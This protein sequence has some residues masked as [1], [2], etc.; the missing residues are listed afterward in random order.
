MWRF[1]LVTFG[2]LG[3]AF[4]ELSGGTD[5]APRD[6]SLQAVRAEI[7][8]QT[9]KRAR[10]VEI[11]R[12]AARTVRIPPT[13]RVQAQTGQD[14]AQVVLAST[15]QPDTTPDAKRRRLTLSNRPDSTGRGVA[16]PALNRKKRETL[17]G[18]GA[19]TGIPS[20]LSP[21][22]QAARA[23]AIVTGQT[24]AGATEPDR[25]QIEPVADRPDATARD[26]RLVSGTRVN[27]RAGPGTHF[28]VV[29]SL[30]RDTR[31]EVLNDPGLGWVELRV[32]DSGMTGWMAEW[33]LVATD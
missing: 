26:I 24:G 10:R 4:F 22:E 16:K 14:D 25:D 28:G 29:D 27:L 20:D 31:V 33:L 3:W 2:F 23:I 17:T 6:G 30:V 18:S 11:A 12:D 32:N 8:A 7:R 5:Y 21:E 15:T 19:A 13:V 1:M 9:D